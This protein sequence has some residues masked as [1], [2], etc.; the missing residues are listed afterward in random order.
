MSHVL[1]FKTNVDSEEQW[2]QASS[3]LNATDSIIKWNIDREDIDKVLR[4]EST[5]PYINSIMKSMEEAGFSCEE[6][7]D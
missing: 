7:L 4:I 3:L 6:L 2:L 5:L 1:I